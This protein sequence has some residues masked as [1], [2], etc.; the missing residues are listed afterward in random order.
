MLLS[1]KNLRQRQP[2]KKLSPKKIGPFPV[3]EP[4]G[5]QAYRL[6]LPKKYSRIWPVFHV[7]LLEAFYPRE[8]DA[9]KEDLSFELADEQE[10]YEVEQVV[11]HKKLKGKLMYKVR[12][13]DYSA[14]YDQ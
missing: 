2:S 14:A 7:S 4:I 6:V 9:I 12:W 13:K 5:T 10:D 8:G 3:E 11:G 1:T